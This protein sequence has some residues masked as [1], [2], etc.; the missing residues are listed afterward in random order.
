MSTA[1]VSYAMWAINNDERLAGAR[2]LRRS[3]VR[4]LCHPAA[5]FLRAE[6]LRTQVGHGVREI[7]QLPLA[8]GSELAR[9]L[10][11]LLLQLVRV[12]PGAAVLGVLLE[13]PCS[14][15]RCMCGLM[16]RR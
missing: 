1:T 4:R 6:R 14:W 15:T 5:G 7:G 2:C 3:V 9:A 11:L 8:H 12:M 16:R 10:I 13:Q